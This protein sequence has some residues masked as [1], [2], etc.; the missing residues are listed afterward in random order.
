[1]HIYMHTMYVY[2][3]VHMPLYVHGVMEVGQPVGICSLFRSLRLQLSLSGL[4]KGAFTSDP[5]CQLGLI[6]FILSFLC[7]IYSTD[8]FAIYSF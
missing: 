1:M 4:V 2:R 7:E 3:Y 5:Q 8:N 6:G